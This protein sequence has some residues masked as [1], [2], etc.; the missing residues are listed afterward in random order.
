MRFEGRVNQTSLTRVV[1]A[2]STTPKRV[3]DPMRR[4]FERLGTA[5]QHNVGARLRGDPLHSRTGR[6]T[7]SLNHKVSG[8]SIGDLRLE[9][10]SQ[11]PIY[12]RAQEYGAEI[13]PVNAKHLAI[14]TG[15]NIT[16][17]GV[18]RYPTVGSLI[19]EFG[20]SR[21]FFRPRPGKNA[22]VMLRDA[23]SGGAAGSRAQKLNKLHKNTP[24]KAALMFV[25]VD[26]VTLPGPK[27]TGAKSRLGF[28]DEF[29][30]LNAGRSVI[31]RVARELGRVG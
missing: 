13:K 18:A 10:R 21:V 19:G 16:S 3:F 27:T 17:A 4:E 24:G 8:S 31:D 15:A 12:A 29:K 1:K 22:L 14:P 20:R 26:K 25:L 6:L 11:G 23:S 30:K 9:C 5:W 7:G 28:F 2:I